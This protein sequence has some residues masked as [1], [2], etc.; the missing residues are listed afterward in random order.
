MRRTDLKIDWT[1]GAEAA[2]EEWLA[3]QPPTAYFYWKD[4]QKHSHHFERHNLASLEA[5]V[6]RMEEEGEPV[7]EEFREALAKL[8]TP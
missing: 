3:G 6:S 7:P 2:G 4:S 5:E 1:I 8:R